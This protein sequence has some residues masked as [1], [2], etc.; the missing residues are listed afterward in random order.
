V[1]AGSR[2][3][4]VCRAEL[5]V[6]HFGEETFDVVISTEAVEHIEDWRAAFSNF[7]R[8]VV[9][10]GL[11]FVTTRSPGF[12]YHGNAMYGDYWRYTVE[13][14]RTIFADFEVLAV[15]PDPSEPGVF[16]KA[17]RPANFRE[18]D[19]SGYELQPIGKTHD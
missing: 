16:V 2:V 4:R 7:K 6:D 1:V 14:M 10:G 19:L 3:D 9:P 12:G 15:Q 11:V 18:V 13:D 5:L 17:R 8:L